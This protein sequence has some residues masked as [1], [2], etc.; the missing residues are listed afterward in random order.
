MIYSISEGIANL[1]TKLQ[2]TAD[3]IWKYSI[4]EDRFYTYEELKAQRDLTDYSGQMNICRI[5]LNEDLVK[6]FQDNVLR[7]PD[8]MRIPWEDPQSFMPE[9]WM[10]KDANET[11]AGRDY[12]KQLESMEEDTRGEGEEGED[13]DEEF[14]EN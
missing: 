12:M 2:S 7:N 14:E 13:G 5:R 9:A 8:T 3:Y 10:P 4:D 6:N 1:V 11:K